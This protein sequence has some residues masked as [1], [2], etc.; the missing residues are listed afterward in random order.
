MS[1]TSI[2]VNI[3]TQQLRLYQGGEVVMEV[4]VSTARNGSGEVSGSECTPRG[5]HRIRAK[6]GGGCAANTV[7]VGRRPTGE[8]FSEALRA[9][10]PQRDWILTR[11]LWLC[12]MEPGRNRGGNRDTMRRYIYIHGCPDSDRMGSPSSHGCVKMRNRDIIELFD[13]VTVGTLVTIRDREPTE[14]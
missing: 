9:E 7:F 11:I 13:R 2:V 4:A 12:G 3:A 1:K 5:R 14:E 6:I 8:L 10:Q